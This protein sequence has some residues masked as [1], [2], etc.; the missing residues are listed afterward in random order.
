MFHSFTQL[1]NGTR[2]IGLLARPRRRT[3]L[4]P[5]QA[6]TWTALESHKRALSYLPREPESRHALRIHLL[7]KVVSVTVHVR[8]RST[9]GTHLTVVENASRARC[10]PTWERRAGNSRMSWSGPAFG[11]ASDICTSHCTVIHRQHKQIGCPNFTDT[12][13]DSAAA[14]PGPMQRHACRW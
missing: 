11:H 1:T 10:Q 13:S 5:G 12:A 6:R 7:L 2:F 3:W 4:R 8:A 14:I 9:S